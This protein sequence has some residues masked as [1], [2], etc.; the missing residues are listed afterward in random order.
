M[1][2]NSKEMLGS[3]RYISMTK[4]TCKKTSSLKFMSAGTHC[5]LSLS[6][7]YSSSPFLPSFLPDL[8][9]SVSHVRYVKLSVN[10][11]CRRSFEWTVLVS[12]PAGPSFPGQEEGRCLPASFNNGTELLLDSLTACT[13][14]ADLSTGIE[15]TL[16]Y[17]TQTCLQCCVVV[18]VVVV[19]A[20]I[21]N[22]DF[23]S[24]DFPWICERDMRYSLHFSLLSCC[25]CYDFSKSKRMA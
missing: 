11:T 20:I 16:K 1:G 22:M 18:V 12:H 10:C 3:T 25:C 21:L 17:A 4:G 24:L 5:L 9:R 23:P 19:V 2:T 15:A 6:T 14:I 13:S 8:V 7:Y